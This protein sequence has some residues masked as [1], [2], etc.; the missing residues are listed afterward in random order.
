MEIEVNAPQRRHL[1]IIHAIDPSRGSE[2]GRQPEVP[3]YL[4]AYSRRS[5]FR[6]TSEAR[7]AHEES[8]P[9]AISS[10]RSECPAAWAHSFVSSISF[11]FW[12]SSS[13]ILSRA[14]V[15]DKMMGPSKRPSGPKAFKPPSNA[16]NTASVCSLTR[17][18]M[19]HGRTIL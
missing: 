3:R 18:L 16:K 14:K 19:R 8:E 5:P 15:T 10:K 1:D 13:T 7:T 2:H 17:P 6:N 4:L 9:V 12:L 11:Q